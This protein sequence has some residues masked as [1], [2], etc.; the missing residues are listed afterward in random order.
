VRE[1]D[2]QVPLDADTEWLRTFADYWGSIGPETKDAIVDLLPDDWSFEGKRML[3]FGSGPGRTLR[4]FLPEAETA[5]FWAVDI[6]KASIEA[7]RADLVPPMHAAVCGYW[8]PLEFESDSFDVVWAISVFT[9]MTDNSIP[10]LL[11]L[12]RVLKPGGLL[13]ATYMGEWTCEF[14]AGEPW[15]ESR[16]GMNVLRHNHPWDDGGPLV[17]I[18]D[19]WLREHWGRAFDV[20]RIAPRIHNFSWAALRKRDVELTPDDIARPGDDERE[21]AAARHNLTQAQR[22]IEYL[23]EQLAAARREADER[24]EATRRFYEESTSFKVTRPLREAVR[25]VRSRRAAKSR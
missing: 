16:I 1:D 7:V 10:W 24:V 17:L 21:Y 15:D 23:T 8:P 11:E 20:D 6:D 18:S 19:W 13:I 14:V 4:E 9:H 2:L 5:E 25:I 3:D 22:E 12:H